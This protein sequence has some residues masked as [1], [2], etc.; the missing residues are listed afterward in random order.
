MTTKK[1]KTISKDFGV[2]L[3]VKAC[4][5][6]QIDFEEVLKW[7]LSQGWRRFRLMSYWN[8]YEKT[9]GSIDLTELDR[10]ISIIAKAGSEVTLCLGARQPRWPESHWPDWAWNLPTG[11]RNSRLL[12]YIEHVVNHYKKSPAIVS[13]QLENEALNRGFGEH[14]DFDRQRL[15]AEFNLVKKLD[16]TRPV[17]MTTS[18]TWGI[19]MRKPRADLYGYTYYT[20]QV[21]KGRYRSTG[22]PKWW[23][24]IRSWLIL[25]LTGHHSFIHELQAEPWGPKPVEHMS[26]AE[27]SESMDAK[28]LTHNIKLAKS[29]GLYPI[30][31]WGAEWWYWRSVKQGDES[32]YNAVAKTINSN[33]L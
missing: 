1:P 18:N 27:Q 7:L 15:V 12:D 33:L 23:Y 6:Y 8:E 21:D 29:T 30:D 26:I 10:H 2:T 9:P 11:E 4:R 24:R 16:N 3:S 28:R 25:I 32:I 31:L 22:L 5:S 13:W 14:G 20:I 17:I 19:P